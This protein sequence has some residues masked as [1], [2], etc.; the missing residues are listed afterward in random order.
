MNI[1]TQD[2]CQIPA[3][4]TKTPPQQRNGWAHNN[5]SPE[6]GSSQANGRNGF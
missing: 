5:P 6:M 3:F 4:R 2:H 1:Y